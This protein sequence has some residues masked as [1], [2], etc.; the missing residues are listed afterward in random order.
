MFSCA[1]KLEKAHMLI[2]LLLLV[3]VV[4]A[5]AAHAQVWKVE[6][7]TFQ[8][9]TLTDQ[10]FLSGRKDGKP[11]TIA[12][13]LRIPIPGN[14][15]LPAVVLVHGS[16][17]VSGYVA[18]WARQ[19]NAIGFATFLIDGFTGRGIVSTV[20][21]QSQ[22]GRLA[23]IVDAYR[24]LELLAK[25][26]HIDPARIAIMGFSRGGQA[27]LYASLKRFQL[28]HGPTDIEFAA[29]IAFYPACNTSYLGDDEV[30]DRPI[31]IFHGSADNF[32]TIAPCRAYVERLWKI[33]KDVRLTEYAGAQHVFDWPLLKKPL[34]LPEAQVARRCRLKEI[35]GERIINS[36]TGQAFDYS[37][38]CVDYGSTL[39]Y[40]AE[41]HRKARRAVTEFLAAT[42][43]PE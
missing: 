43:A 3:A 18:D 33:G 31:R 4:G 26:P 35:I 27:A 29:Y 32:N 12:G 9:S 16:G 19:L 28:M 20:D 37:D 30:A 11:V 40:D 6:L 8:S 14:G 41:A 1:I 7:H 42:L 36:D 13:E 21:D 39:A 24:A 38:P 15:R 25:H 34:K 10:E 22:L 17:G 2:G 23:L 5:S